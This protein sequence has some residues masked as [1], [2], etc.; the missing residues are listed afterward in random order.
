[1]MQLMIMTML[2]HEEAIKAA[3]VAKGVKVVTK[4]RYEKKGEEIERLLLV[5]INEKQ[6]FGN[7]IHFLLH[8][9]YYNLL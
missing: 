7:K 1:M 4:Q 6:T 8:I 5:W 9:P 3:D 2:K